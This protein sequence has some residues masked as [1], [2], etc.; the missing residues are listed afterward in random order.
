MFTAIVTLLAFLLL[1]YS[2]YPI[3]PRHNDVIFGGASAEL[4]VMAFIWRGL[5]VRRT[6][7]VKALYR[8][9]LIYAVLIRI[10]L[11]AR[12]ALSEW[13]APA[14]YAALFWGSFTV[15]TRA[16][17][18]PSSGRRTAI[19][20]TSTWVPM[21]AAAIWLALTSQQEIPGPAFVLGC[22]VFGAFA[23]VTATT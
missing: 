4:A 19:V 8:I 16:F 9:D 11:G 20:S 6:L 10:S 18:V 14:A 5:L 3:A 7:S 15:C 1:M 21:L 22:L 13:P 2:V 17:V 23:I 12:A